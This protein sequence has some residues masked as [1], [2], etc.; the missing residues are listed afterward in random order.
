MDSIQRRFVISNKI[1]NVL[2]V[3][4]VGYFTLG[5]VFYVVKI[6]ISAAGLL[7][8]VEPPAYLPIEAEQSYAKV[9]GFNRVQLIYENQNESIIVWATSKLGWNNVAG[10]D[11]TLSLPD[12]TPAYFTVGAD[13]I[14][15]FSWTKGKVEYSI[16]YRGTRDLGKEEFIKTALSMK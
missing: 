2:T 16:D 10:W 3:L 13:D 14:Q 15:M 6:P 12:G 5:V 11:E 7:F 8:K 4:L 9:I 1:R